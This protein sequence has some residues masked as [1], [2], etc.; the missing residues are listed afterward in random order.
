MSNRWQAISRTNVEPAL[1]CIYATW[2]IYRIVVWLNPRLVTPDT[3]FP[4]LWCHNKNNGISNHQPYDCLFIRRFR[5]R[6][7]KTPTLRPTGLCAGN[8]PVTGE[9]PIQRASNAVNVS[10]WWRH[11]VENAFWQSCCCSL[12]N[13][14][15]W[16]NFVTK[17]SLQFNGCMAKL[18][19]TSVGNR[20]EQLSS[21]H[22][23]AWYDALTMSRG[24][25]SPKDSQY[26][27][28]RARPRWWT[29]RSLWV[30]C[31]NSYCWS[32]VIHDDIIKWKHF[33]RYWPLCGVF[34]GHRWISLTKA[35]DAEVWHF[36][37]L[38]LNKRLSKQ[39]WGWWFET[40]SL[41]LWCHSNDTCIYI[42]YMYT[43]IPWNMHSVLLC[44][45]LLWSYHQS[46]TDS[47]TRPAGPLFIVTTPSYWYR[48]FP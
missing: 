17:P 44:L 25:W 27:R 3:N 26:R 18:R 4:L 8:S 31:L 13:E 32:Y 34:T 21:S 12:F 7:K 35:S 2:D 9:F 23:Q 41:P 28:P 11:H 43:Y 5:V 46:F 33:L 29:L 45:V 40:P 1:W 15:S 47:F 48:G 22:H 39:S 14:G 20:K 30:F 42:I 6:S 16:T 24:H 38:G 36:L 37:D 10:I 19:L